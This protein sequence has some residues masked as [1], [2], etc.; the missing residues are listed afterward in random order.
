MKIIHKRHTDK[1]C[2]FPLD[3]FE[4]ICIRDVVMNHNGKIEATTGQLY[5]FIYHP[6]GSGDSDD[7]TYTFTDDSGYSMHWADATWITIHFRI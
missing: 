6:K 7:S 3:N 2:L 5:E 1:S 4:A